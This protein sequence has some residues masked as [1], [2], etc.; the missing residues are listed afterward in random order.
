MQWSREGAHSI[1][2]IRTSRFSK[3]W[4]QDWEKAQAQI[5]KNAAWNNVFEALTLAVGLLR[6]L[7]QLFKLSV[8]HG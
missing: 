4:E 5:Y 1:L 6:I 8:W 2:Q 7:E 3:T